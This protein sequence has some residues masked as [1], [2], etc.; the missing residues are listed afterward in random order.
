MPTSANDA[1]TVRRDG[2]AL[3]FTGALAR[4]AVSSL[5]RE[6]PVDM[7]GVRYL[8]LSAVERLDSSGLALLS[9]LSMRAKGGMTVIG[10]PP[11]LGALRV[12]YRLTDTLA[13]STP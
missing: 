5:W 12:A 11:G 8:D 1:V 2:D 10:N 6:L 4:D 9:T 7:T 3:V 13:I